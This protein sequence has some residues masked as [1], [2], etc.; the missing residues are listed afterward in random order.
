MCW[1]IC[2]K[3]C[4]VIRPK[5]NFIMAVQNF[6]G[7]PQKILRAKNKQNLAWFWITLNFNG[8]YLRNGWRS[9]KS[10][11]CMIFCNSS[12]VQQKVVNI[13]PLTVEISRRSLQDVDPTLDQQLHPNDVVAKSVGTLIPLSHHWVFGCGP[14]EANGSGGRATTTTTTTSQCV[15]IPAQIDFFVRPYFCP[16]GVLHPQIFTHSREW[17]NL[18]NTS[19]LGSPL[20]FCLKGVQN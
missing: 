13:G 20:Q 2:V 17:P 9:S 15:I 5:L 4:T 10:N 14:A 8:K 16:L 19:P 12:C 11:K 1:P 7:L 18:A 3:F 6:G